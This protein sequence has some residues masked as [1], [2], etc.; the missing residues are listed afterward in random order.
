MIKPKKYYKLLKLLKGLKQYKINIYMA[1]S[2]TVTMNVNIG[3]RV[4]GTLS[5]SRRE[6]TTKSSQICGRP[7]ELESSWYLKGDD[8]RRQ[9][10]QHEATPPGFHQPTFLG[11]WD[12]RYEQLAW[13]N[14]MYR[15]NWGKNGPLGNLASRQGYKGQSFK[16]FELHL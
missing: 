6:H 7:T 2:K 1:P 4:L 12:S 11:W 14:W 16:H 8:S 10:T 15:E 5:P 3:Y 9:G 13:P